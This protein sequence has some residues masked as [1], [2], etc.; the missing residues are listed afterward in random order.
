MLAAPLTGRDGAQPRRRSTWPTATT[1]T[2]TDDD[3]AILVQLAQM[4]SIAI[5]NTL[6]A[7]E[8]EANRIKDEFLVDAVAT[9]CARRSTR[10]SAGRSSCRSE[11]LEAARSGTALEVIERN[12][13]AQTKL[14]ED[15]LDV[16]RITT[17]KLRL[18]VAPLRA[19]R[20]R[21]TPPSTRCGR[22]PRR[23][24]I[25]VGVPTS[26]GDRRPHRRRPRPA[27]AGR[28]E[29][30]V[31]N[32]V[33][34]TPD[35]GRIEVRLERVGAQPCSCASRDT[36][37]GID[38]QFLPYVFDRF[39][40]ADSTQHPLARRAGHRPDDRPP[41]RRAARRR[42][43]A[44][45]AGEGH[46]STFIVTLPV[47][48][49]QLSL[50]QRERFPRR[51]SPAELRISACSRRRR[52]RRARCAGGRCARAIAGGRQT[53]TAASVKKRWP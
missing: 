40:Q 46:G 38:P 22:R 5:E 23:S 9:S 6:F 52:R 13:Q 16:S 11:P 19:G 17:G 4:A 45:S 15:L 39:R 51:C 37:Q 8:R 10:S 44:E 24:G 29:P 3:E 32:A 27:A 47:G 1:A 7:E 53:T 25:D 35:G 50:V 33:K 26:T 49:S 28:L 36:G 31:N 2:F 18:N 12:A 30:A 43:A 34:F 14:I 48:G 20:D 41:H 42:G 21:R